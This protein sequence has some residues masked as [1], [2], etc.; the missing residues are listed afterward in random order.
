M[1]TKAEQARRVWEVKENQNKVDINTRI[2]INLDPEKFYKFCEGLT[3]AN[4]RNVLSAARLYLIP[5]VLVRM[6]TD[7]IVA[8]N[9]VFVV[10]TEDVCEVSADWIEVWG[11]P[12]D[13]DDLDE[14]EP[15]EEIFYR[16]DYTRK[17]HPESYYSADT[18]EEAVTFIMSKIGTPLFIDDSKIAAVSNS[19]F[20]YSIFTQFK[21]VTGK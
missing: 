1:T 6:M 17:S 21:K 5:T 3:R 11:D 4:T 13:D 10:G 18:I 16:V 8:N 20:D 19:Y 14:V 15:V 2:Y 7:K 12:D 9:A